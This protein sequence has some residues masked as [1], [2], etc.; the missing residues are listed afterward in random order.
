MGAVFFC[1]NGSGEGATGWSSA[2]LGL[3]L[4]G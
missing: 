3:V 2:V 4:V 1:E